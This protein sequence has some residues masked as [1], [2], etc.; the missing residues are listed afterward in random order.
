VTEG[1]FASSPAAP[2][3]PSGG[4]GR[5]LFG[6]P[7]GLTSLFLTQMW[8]E[9]SYFGL[10]ALL[11]YYMTRHLHFPQAQS[12]LIYGLYGA[13][14]FFSP[15]F[16]GII[17]DRW[18]GRT[19]S[20][21]LGGLLMMAGH[22][23]MAFES[24]LFP[25]LALVAIGNGL[26]IPPLAVQVGSLYAEDDPRRSQAFSAY[27]MGINLGGLL[28][29]LVCGTLGELYG[30]HWGFSAAGI[31]MAVGL[32]IYLGSRRLLPPEP[33]ANRAAHV[34]LPPMAEKDWRNL[35]LLLAMVLV[36]VLFRIGYEQSGNVIALWVANQTDRHVGALEVP[37]T[38]FQAIN[39]L[40]IILLTPLLM[41]YW[42]RHDHDGTPAALLRRMSVGCAIA[43][44]SMVVMVG[45]AM[46]HGSTGQSVGP[47]WV[48]VYFLFLTVGELLTIPVGLSLLGMLSPV[49]IAAMLMGAWYIAKF[50]GSLLAG[51]MGA[52]WGTIPAAAFFAVGTV[53]VLAASAILL[54]MSRAERRRHDAGL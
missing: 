52:F 50:L 2:A 15:F 42:R 9:F 37:A 35:R 19:R 46:V 39:P 22:F 40:L 28:A 6:H 12:S 1:P 26:F 11:V 27:Y 8:A 38:W 36:I 53:S 47:G 13:A 16:G 41:R 20:V 3:L 51:V 14:A 10:Q 17:A 54:A 30:W 5:T 24:L 32:A 21:V 18:L 4:A 45:A 33:L 7:P 34:A 48:L 49:R 43:A 23:L 44:L 25:A 29:P 31:G